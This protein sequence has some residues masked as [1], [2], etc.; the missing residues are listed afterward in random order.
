MIRNKLLLIL[1]FFSVGPCYASQF[2]DYY[3]VGVQYLV[4]GDYTNAEVQFAIAL[5]MDPNHSELKNMIGA[6]FF[7]QQKFEEAYGYFNSAINQAPDG[8]HDEVLAANLIQTSIKWK[9]PEE[10]IPI[11]EKALQLHPLH[12]VILY[13]SA[14]VYTAIRNITDNSKRYGAELYYRAA[15]LSPSWEDAWKLAIENYFSA[16]DIVRGYEILMEGLNYIRRDTLF[17]SES[18][19]YFLQSIS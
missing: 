9:G 11:C 16:S 1:V 2:S 6:T 4:A 10:T 5:A 18:N 19:V 8:W 17:S 15:L 13:N 14:Q 3:D 12:H 7:A